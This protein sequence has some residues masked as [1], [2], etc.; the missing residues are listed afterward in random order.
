[1]DTIKIAVAGVG[2]CVSSLLQGIEYY[3]TKKI[4]EGQSKTETDT[5][6]GV[7]GRIVCPF[8]MDG[9][10]IKTLIK[11]FSEAL[12]LYKG[13]DWKGAE[14]AFRKVL[15]VRAD[16][17]PSK[18]YIERCQQLSVA[19]PPPDWDGVFTMTKK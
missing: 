4:E 18:V 9:E 5:Y 16:D 6:K 17:G 14:A 13:R 3:K 15:E 11:M 19:P 8:D 12:A 2:N 10:T 1:M 7:G